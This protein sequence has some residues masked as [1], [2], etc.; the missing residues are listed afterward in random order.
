MSEFRSRGGGASPPSSP[1]MGFQRR[2]NNNSTPTSPVQSPSNYQ[3]PPTSPVHSPPTRP[4]DSSS[5]ESAPTPMTPPSDV[6]SGDDHPFPQQ[7]PPK[8]SNG[9]SVSAPVQ[10]DNYDPYHVQQSRNSSHSQPG[11]LLQRALSR[12]SPLGRERA[13]RVRSVNRAQSMSQRRRV[14]KFSHCRRR[15]LFKSVA[16]PKF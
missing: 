13:V 16:T 3:S 9:R 10:N 2:G 7:L 5:K 14:L 11:Q 8:A 12:D 4:Y 1:Q 6:Y 15:L